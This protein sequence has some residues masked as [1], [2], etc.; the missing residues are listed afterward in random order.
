MLIGAVSVVYILSKGLTLSDIGLMK[1]LQ[2]LIIVFLDIPFAYIADRYSRKLSVLLSVLFGSIWLFLM[3]IGDSRLVLYSAE[4]FNAISIA[5]TSGAFT[6]Y[7]INHTVS[8]K[9]DKIEIKK[10]L[11]QF[12]KYQYFGMAIFTLLGSAFISVESPIIWYVASIITFSLLIIGL[13][14]LPKDIELSYSDTKINTFSKDFRT[15]ISCFHESNVLI[16]VIL[17]LITV[18]FFYQ[19]LIQYWQPLSFSN[20]TD[21]PEN[22]FF[23]G[24]IFSLTLV[25]Q[26]LA[27]YISEKIKNIELTIFIGNLINL[28][29]LFIFIWSIY[30][31]LSLMPIAI[32]LMFSGN[33]LVTIGVNSVFHSKVPEHLRTTFDSVVST[34]LRLLL[35]V[36]LP[37]ISISIEFFGWWFFS[38]LLAVSIL[39]PMFFTSS[40]SKKQFNY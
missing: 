32:V 10:V 39:I 1:A 15:L 5:L 24:I 4:V 38:S 11:S 9:T 8:D 23:Y 20:L 19:V 33:R 31:G 25:S 12:S 3:G 29:A 7:L 14:I 2:A 18:S 28:S 27:S 35:I 40:P 22:G 37:I 17:S 16:T 34:L 13:L 36:V 26:S 30:S 6:A 21:P